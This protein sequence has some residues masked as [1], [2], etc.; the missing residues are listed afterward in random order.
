MKDKIL[1]L[2]IG[3][4]I[5]AVLTSAGFFIYE[6]NNSSATQNETQNQMMERPDRAM[7]NGEMPDGKT[8]PEKPEGDLNDENKD[9]S[10]L[11][12]E[13]TEKT[14]RNSSK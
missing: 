11:K 14:S 10:K 9:N 12:N 5:G 1:I 2:V 6:K 4:L 8:P 13:S 7:P 3:I